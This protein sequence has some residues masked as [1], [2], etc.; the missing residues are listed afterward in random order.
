MIVYIHCSDVGQLCNKT[1]NTHHRLFPPTTHYTEGPAQRHLS[2]VTT[3]DNLK[4]SRLNRNS[5][6]TFKSCSWSNV[7]SLTG[8]SMSSRFL[9][10]FCWVWKKI[11]LHNKELVSNAA[12]TE[13]SVALNFSDTQTDYLF[14]GYAASQV[15][16]HNRHFILGEVNIKLYK[17]YTLKIHRGDKL[18]RTHL[19]RQQDWLVQIS[20][21]CLTCL[22]ALLN[23]AIVFSL[24]L[25]CLSNTEQK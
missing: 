11:Y 14:S 5:I 12:R 19:P 24:I 6:F 3:N 8:T 1:K 21:W 9:S 15:V 18:N 16:V 22:A 25:W 2:G 7:R 4:Q 10:F 17:C 23:E 20:A 13:C